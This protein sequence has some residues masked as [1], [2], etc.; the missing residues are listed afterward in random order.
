M[1]KKTR[2]KFLKKILDKEL[3]N[4]EDE[5]HRKEELQL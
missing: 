4:Q 2:A 3:K 1:I 5:E